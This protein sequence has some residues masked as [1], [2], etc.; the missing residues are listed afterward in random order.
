MWCT[1]MKFVWENKWNAPKAR[2]NAEPSTLPHFLTLFH[3]TSPT[4]TET[5]ATE[6]PGDFCTTK[7]NGSFLDL[8]SRI[9]LRHLMLLTNNIPFV[10]LSITAATFLISYVTY[11]S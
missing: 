4:S 10:T 9:K 11:S 3:L 5:V 7:S 8:S 2:I 1:I 6:V